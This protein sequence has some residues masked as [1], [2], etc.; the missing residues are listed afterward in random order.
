MNCHMP[1][2]L[3]RLVAELEKPL[4]ISARYTRSPGRLSSCRRAR[5]MRLVARHACEPDAHALAA[6]ALEEVEVVL[7]AVVLVVGIDVDVPGDR[8]GRERLLRVVVRG[9][10]IVECL[11]HR[12][13]GGAVG[14]KPELGGEL[15][16]WHQRI[17]RGRGR[18]QRLIGG[19]DRGGCGHRRPTRAGGRVSSVGGNR[20]GHRR[21]RSPAA[22][23][24]HADKE[25]QQEEPRHR[26]TPE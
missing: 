20:G 13:V 14:G 23:G 15:L 21:S 18:Q 19:R 5:I 24:G 9:A 7:D 17:E 10:G 22:T 3:D 8:R 25:Q 26:P 11:E 12:F 6:L 2:A 16:R 4:S 1:T